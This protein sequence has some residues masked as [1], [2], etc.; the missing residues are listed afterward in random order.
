[1]L[2][3]PGSASAV[4]ALP[5]ARLAAFSRAAILGGLGVGGA[6]RHRIDRRAADLADVGQ[7]VGVNRQEKGSVGVA[8]ER[9]SAVEID[10]LVALAGHQHLVP[11]GRLELAPQFEA[12]GQDDG[13]FHDAADTAGAAVDPAMTRIEHN[14]RQGGGG[15]RT[16]RRRSEVRRRGRRGERGV[17]AG[18]DRDREPRGLGALSDRLQG[19]VGWTGP[20]GE[21]N[22]DS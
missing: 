22:D 12:E 21:V 10:V 9:Y 5:G 15:R 14:D 16:G 8:R 3:T 20:A 19:D 7:R 4:P 2:E 13:L 1:M 18:L 17:V 6:I 11:P